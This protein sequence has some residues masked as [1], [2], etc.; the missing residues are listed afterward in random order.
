MRLSPI[1]TIRKITGEPKDV[2]QAVERLRTTVWLDDAYTQAG[3]ASWPEFDKKYVERG[4]SRSNLGEKWR[5]GTVVPGL[6][7]AKKLNEQLPGTLAVF[8]SPVWALLENRPFSKPEIGRVMSDYRPGEAS[9]LPFFWLFP[10]DE[11]RWKQGRC[12]PTL[13]MSDTGGL[14]H[15]GDMWGFIALLWTM[16]YAEA[17]GDQQLHHRASQD[18]Y[19]AMPMAI[20]EPWLANHAAALIELT[21]SIRARSLYSFYLFDV[22][23]DVIKRQAADPTYEPVRELRRRDPV[24]GRFQ[25]VEDPVLPAQIIPGRERALMARSR[26]E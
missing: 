25:E 21:E 22:D 20:R 10:N 6:Y 19:R 5:K 11:A 18:M 14:V 9:G 15:R 17:D 26:P 12:A 16:R 24:T 23:F 2:A 1:D 8:K 7:S 3:C 13:T 4:R